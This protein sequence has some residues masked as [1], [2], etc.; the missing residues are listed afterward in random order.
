[1]WTRFM[2]ARV[3]LV[4][5]SAFLALVLLCGAVTLF[6]AWGD[7]DDPGSAAQPPAPQSSAPA[8]NCPS[9]AE[10]SVPTAAPP[11]LRWEPLGPV[12]LPYSSTAGPCKVTATTAAGYAHTPTG[13]LIAAAQVT[14]RVSVTTPIEVA[15]DTIAGQVLPGQA[16]DQLLADTRRRAG[17]PLTAEDAGRL[18]A[19]SVLSYSADTAVLSLA[20]SNA[21]LAGQ[22]VTLP[23]TVRWVDG[24]WRLVAPPGGSWD[25]SAAV[26][27][28]LDGYVEWGTG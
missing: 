6:R 13:A 18:T 15:T 28:V 5:A 3:W 27:Q 16:R 26:T 20:L 22:Y 21:A 9:D 8:S 19:F 14:G 23:V 7:K 10:Q 1:M 2:S 17:R 25:S 4:A 11:G 12:T 24:D